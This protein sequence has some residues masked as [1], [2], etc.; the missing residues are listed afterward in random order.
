M[1]QSRVLGFNMGCETCL[2]IVIHP[3]TAL[4]QCRDLDNVT[5]TCQLYVWVKII[6]SKQYPQI[7]QFKREHLMEIVPDIIESIML[8]L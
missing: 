7:V 1:L 3:E 5:H 4:S 6:S 2:H 8:K